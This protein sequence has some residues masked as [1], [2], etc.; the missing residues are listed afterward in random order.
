MV[1]KH[2]TDTSVTVNLLIEA[3]CSGVISAASPL[4]AEKRDAPKTTASSTFTVVNG[5]FLNIFLTLA[6]TQG[7]LVLPP[8]KSTSVM[9]FSFK[10]ASSIAFSH[11][12]SV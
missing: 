2:P 11:N 12:I 1:P 10:P 9:S 8:T 5:S 6:V 3:F 7:T 4:M